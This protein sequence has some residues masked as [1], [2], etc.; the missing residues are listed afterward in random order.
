M[1]IKRGL[2]KHSGSLSGGEGSNNDDL[3]NFNL[4]C[5]TVGSQLKY[6]F[7][8]IFRFIFT[9]TYSYNQRRVSVMVFDGL[10][11]ATADSNLLSLFFVISCIP[12]TEKNGICSIL[13]RIRN[14]TRPGSGSAL[15]SDPNHSTSDLWSFYAPFISPTC[16]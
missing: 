5:F 3:Q 11:I 8:I 9:I 10:V 12:F 4:E 2:K 6:I 13:G 16:E 15:K 7:Y 14:C 1:Y